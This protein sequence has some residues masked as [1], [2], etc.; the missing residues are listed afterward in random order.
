LFDAELSP[1]GV[2]QTLTSETR[3]R[4]TQVEFDTVL[5]SPM[6]RAMQT[7]HG[8]LKDHPRFNELK[9]IIVPFI[10]EHLHTSGDIPGTYERTVED[11]KRLF[12]NVD[13]DTFFE[14][15]PNR[16]LWPVAALKDAEVKIEMLEHIKAN[17]DTSV[18][19]A[20]FS[21]LSKYLPDC[22]ESMLTK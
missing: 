18:T 16:E 7:A 9:F 6:R 5:V 11:A 3:D 19:E 4:L 1:L 14:N 12:P 13:T 15:L 8:L 17:P 2:E 10:R 21:V 22:R 20:I